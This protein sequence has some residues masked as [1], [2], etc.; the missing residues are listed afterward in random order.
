MFRTLK[1]YNMPLRTSAHTKTT[2]PGHMISFSG[3]PGVITSGDD[4]Y[5]TSSGLVALE[6]TIGNSN[7]SLWQQVTPKGQVCYRI[8]YE[9][10]SSVQ[11]LYLTDQPQKYYILVNAVC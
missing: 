1:Y 11:I 5:I 10:M 8:S 3:Y 2:V 9:R 4:F 7:A 6:T